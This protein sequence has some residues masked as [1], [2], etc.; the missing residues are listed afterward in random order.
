MIFFLKMYQ[1]GSYIEES[2]FIFVNYLLSKHFESRICLY[3]VQT[4]NTATY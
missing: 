4:H 1:L 3:A 2:M